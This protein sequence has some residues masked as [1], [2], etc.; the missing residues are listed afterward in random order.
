MNRSFLVSEEIN[1]VLVFRLGIDFLDASNSGEYKTLSVPLLKNTQ[2]LVFDLTG[3]TFIDSS[4]LGA[5]LST[6]RNLSERGGSFRVCNITP[7]IK[8]LF[9]LVRINKI[10]PIHITLEEALQAAQQE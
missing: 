1:D 9:E 6:M 8:V 7:A 4:G 3:V 10:L 5:L 2:K